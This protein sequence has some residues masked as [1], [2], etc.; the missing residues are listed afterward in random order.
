MGPVMTKKYPDRI[1]NV[2]TVI[3]GNCKNILN[4]PTNANKMNSIDVTV[5]I[6]KI[7]R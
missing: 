3:G 6:A 5:P 7:N 4:T 1:I 2:V